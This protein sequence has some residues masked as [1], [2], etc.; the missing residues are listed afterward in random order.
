[1]K[2]RSVLAALACAWSA[3]AAPEGVRTAAP[4]RAGVLAWGN[5]G[6][7]VDSGGATLH[8]LPDALAPGIDPVATAHGLWLVSASGAL[9]CWEPDTA[10]S[11]R[12]RCAVAFA[13]P[14]HALAASPDGRW[15]LAAH[16]QRLSLLDAGGEIVRTYEGTDLKREHRGAAASLFTLSRRRSFVAAWPALGELWEISLDPDAAP[17]FDGLVHDYRMSRGHREAGLPRRT[18]RAAR[19]A[20]A[21]LRLCRRS[22]ALAGRDAG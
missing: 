14:V 20:A 15:A 6:C 13:A 10:S 8:R 22:R 2:R 12:L 3:A 7:W 5:D 17:I 9:R 19:A 18:P 1:M 4:L 21:C 16:G 11:W